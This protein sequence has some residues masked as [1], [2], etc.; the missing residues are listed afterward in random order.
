MNKGILLIG[1]GDYYQKIAYNLLKSIRKHS[2]TIKVAIITDDDSTYFLSEFDY[3]IEPN[4]RH[5][6]EDSR[7]NPFKLKTF[8][9]EYTPFEHTMYLDVDAICLRKIDELFDFDFLIQE[10]ARYTYET[11]DKCAMVWV[12]KAGL[13]LKNVYDAYKL[14]HSTEYPEYNSSIIIFKKEH[15]NYFKQ[16]QKN[17]HDRRISWKD[18]GGRYPDELAFN[19]ASAQLGIYN[20]TKRKPVYFQWENKIDNLTSITAQYNF[21]GLAGGYHGD[22]LK[23]M[24]NALVKHLDTPFKKWESNKKIFH[25]KR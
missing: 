19:L 22:K 12:K 6:L 8:I 1:I 2:P 25:E 11:A 15:D 13:T 23:N 3:V 14:E 9:N 17:Y 4:L 20:T 21:L 5:Y 16:V 10:V 7:I 18:I 24:Y